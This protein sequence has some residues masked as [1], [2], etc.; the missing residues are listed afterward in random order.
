MMHTLHVGRSHQVLLFAYYSLLGCTFHT[1]ENVWVHILYFYWKISW[2]AQKKRRTKVASRAF[3]GEY[4]AFNWY[5]DG[6]HLDILYLVSLYFIEFQENYTHWCVQ[7]VTGL[8]DS[9]HWTFL[10][11]HTCVFGNGLIFWNQCNY[12]NNNIFLHNSHTTRSHQVLLFPYY[13]L[14]GCT[15]SHSRKMCRFIFSI[16][17]GTKMINI[18]TR[19]SIKFGCF[20][21]SCSSSSV[22]YEYFSVCQ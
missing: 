10:N 11:L 6:F 12:G 19:F 7:I 4:L 3:M 22:S 8:K 20:V 13:S 15:L 2:H 14:L 21:C 1:P 16:S 9:V 5:I 17:I 18:L